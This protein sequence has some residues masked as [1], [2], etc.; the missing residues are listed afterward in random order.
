L[1]L[2][3]EVEADLADELAQHLED[4]YREHR[5]RGTSDADARRLV[6]EEL[7][8]EGSLAAKLSDVVRRGAPAPVVGTTG[9]GGFTGQF[10]Q[11]LRYALRAMQRSPGFTAV[12][13]LTLALGI[14]A[15]TTIFSVVNGVL[16]SPLPYRQP[17]RL[18][19][20]WGTAPEK[21][22]PEVEF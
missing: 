6:L 7:D 21:Q 2:T 10:R 12:V 16:L 19:A 20:F 18:V 3:P 9:H 22:L 4:R 15:A 8:E 11:D 5:I 17:D 14:G 1:R 13:V